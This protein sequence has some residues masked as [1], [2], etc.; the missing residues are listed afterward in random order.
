MRR[1]FPALTGANVKMFP[2]GIKINPSDLDKSAFLPDC[3]G[4]DY[5]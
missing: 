5:G 1:I 4:G 2:I 3:S